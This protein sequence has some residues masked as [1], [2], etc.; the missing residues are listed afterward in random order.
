[1]PVA[2]NYGSTDHL[3]DNSSFMS[4]EDFDKEFE[5]LKRTQNKKLKPFF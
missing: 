5:E 2:V 4:D 3:L 1:M